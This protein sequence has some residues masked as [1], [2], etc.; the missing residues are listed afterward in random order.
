MLGAHRPALY[1]PEGLK[2]GSQL[3]AI[4]NHGY[5]SSLVSERRGSTKRPVS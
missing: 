4:V 5:I 1:S 2:L 3:V